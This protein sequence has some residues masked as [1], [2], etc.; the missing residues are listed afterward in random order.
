ML[1]AKGIFMQRE[2][3]CIAQVHQPWPKGCS[4]GKRSLPITGRGNIK[5]KAKRKIKIK[6]KEK[7]KKWKGI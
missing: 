3:L 6:R 5:E 1:H 2:S 7:V 4:E